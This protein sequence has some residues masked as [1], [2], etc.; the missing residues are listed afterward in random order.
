MSP[1]E[2][3]CELVRPVA[4]LQLSVVQHEVPVFVNQLGSSC[5]VRNFKIK[6]VKLIRYHKGLLILLRCFG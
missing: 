1:I 3:K 4:E 6:V 5:Y 2:K